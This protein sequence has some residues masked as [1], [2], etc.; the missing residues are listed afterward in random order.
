MLS[1]FAKQY[2]FYNYRKKDFY[3]F[4]ESSHLLTFM[5][6]AKVGVNVK[7]GPTLLK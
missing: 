7:V 3:A 6:I 5:Y 2:D 4:S 1:I